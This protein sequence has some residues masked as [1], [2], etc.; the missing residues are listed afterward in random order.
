MKTTQSPHKKTTTTNVVQKKEDPNRVRQIHMATSAPSD[1]EGKKKTSLGE[2]K[3]FLRFKREKTGLQVSDQ[4]AFQRRQCD[5]DRSQ[6]R[7]E[8]LPIPP[9]WEMF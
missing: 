7:L 3:L 9:R 4:Q 6:K 2:A 8:Q 1:N 5:R